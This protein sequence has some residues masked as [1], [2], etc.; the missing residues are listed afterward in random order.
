[1]V[2]KAEYDARNQVETVSQGNAGDSGKAYFTQ[3]CSACHAVDIRLIGPPIT[4]IAAIYKGKPEGIVTWSMAPGKKRA[5]FIPMPSFSQ[6]DPKELLA[7]A[8]Y[9]L[10]IGST[11]AHK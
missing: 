1:L 11:P 10:E 4:E 7:I 2:R 3:Y 5:G 9:M 6:V 8:R